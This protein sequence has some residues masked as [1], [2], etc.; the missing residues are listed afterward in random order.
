MCVISPDE[1]PSNMTELLP[2]PPPVPVSLPLT[3]MEPS[4]TLLWDKT[5]NDGPVKQVATEL[6]SSRIT[7]VKGPLTSVVTAFHPFPVLVPV[8]PGLEAIFA[9]Q[10]EAAFVAWAPEAGDGAALHPANA[11]C[12]EP[13]TTI[14]TVPAVATTPP[15]APRV[16]RGERRSVRGP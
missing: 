12:A 5:V 9:W 2:A 4:P 11:G 14:E 6:P 3:D 13:S 16:S 7:T 8:N 1:V 15:R 10:A